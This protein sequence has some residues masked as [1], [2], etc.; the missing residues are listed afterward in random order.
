L[1]QAERDLIKALA[2]T[3]DW[4]WIQTI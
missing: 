4:S 3:E 2:E 1:T